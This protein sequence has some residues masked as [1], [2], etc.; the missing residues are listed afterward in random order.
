LLRRSDD[1][2][3]V[4]DFVYDFFLQDVAKPLN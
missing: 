4:H 2:V 3:F 1:P